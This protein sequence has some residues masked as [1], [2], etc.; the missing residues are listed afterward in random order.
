MTVTDVGDRTSFAVDV[1]TNVS[2]K[3]GCLLLSRAKT[4]LRVAVVV[5]EDVVG[6]WWS[7][8]RLTLYRLSVESLSLSLA[9]E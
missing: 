5:T 4:R 6:L 7:S 3:K 2:R 8:A 9:N 1:V